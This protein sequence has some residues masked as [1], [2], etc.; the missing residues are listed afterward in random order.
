MREHDSPVAGG[1]S[2]RD[3]GFSRRGIGGGVL[4][5]IACGVLFVILWG[6]VLIGR[7]VMVGGDVL[8]A[9]NPWA[10]TAVAAPIHNLL[11]SDGIEEFLPWF[12]VI[13]ESFAAGRLPLW[14]PY[15]LFGAP[16]LGN[17]QAAPFS[18]FTLLAVL[19][20]GAWGMSLM[21]LVKLW[22]AGIGMVVYLRRLGVGGVG[23]VLGGLAFATSSFMVVWLYGQNAS[24]AAWLPW[25]FAAVEW[26]LRRPRGRRLAALALVIALQFLAGEPVASFYL[27]LGVAMYGVVRCSWPGNRAALPGLVAAALLGVVVAGV[28]LLPFATLLKQSGQYELVDGGT[29][30][31]PLTYLDSWLA[32]NLHGNP[33]IDGFPGR[34]PNYSESTGFVGVT[35]LTLSV[36][37]LVFQWKRNRSVAL[38]LLVVGLISAAVVYGVLTPVVDQL[39]LFRA[40][41]GI[42]LTMLMCFVVASLGGIG[43][44][45]VTRTKTRTRWGLIPGVIGLAALGA[46]LV[47]VALMR[48]RG[49]QVDSLGPGLPGGWIAFWLVFAA[50][51][52][53]GAVGLAAAASLGLRR[54]AVSGL[55]V[56]ALLEAGVF[57]GPYQPQ[58]SPSQVPPPS[59][60]MNWLVAHAGSRPVAAQGLAL[61]PETATLYGLHD[62]RG[63]DQTVSPRTTLFWEYADP[64]YPP[65]PRIALTHPGAQWLAAAG[66][67]YFMSNGDTPLPGTITAYQGEGVTISRVPDARP[68]AFAAPSVRWVGSAEQAA[69]GMAPDPLGAV[70]LEGAG[71]EQAGH[72]TVTVVSRQPGDVQLRVRAAQPA[73]IVVLQSYTPGWSATVDGRQT[74]ITPADVLFQAVR[75][76]AGSHQV[77]LTY[78]PLSVVVG[79]GLTGAGLLLMILLIVFNPDL[80]RLRRARKR[81]L[82]THP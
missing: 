81:R 76:P 16:L 65:Q 19:V 53:V 48:V 46:V 1:L 82:E 13:R 27:C 18:P 78:R 67:T 71:S 43:L 25:V 28:Q 9:S 42:R 70:Y 41:P 17:G 64:G 26:Y 49:A 47:G 20:G 12:Q 66:V 69:R 6:S 45:G 33:S 80:S 61:V 59:A 51:C 23:A 14:N 58:L 34:P 31:L 52:L 77:V 3:R 24:V 72:A 50:A 15:A 32:P 44:D 21:M 7:R 10:S 4:F 56:L 39:P 2:G 30:R 35:A 54:V 36:P 75:V 22:V 57:A 73:E 62:A 11:V 63:Y 8:Y 40:A 74:A 55:A 60:A 37:G 38:A 29:F 5:G 68:F 79:F